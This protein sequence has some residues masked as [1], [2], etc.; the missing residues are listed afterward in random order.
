MARSTQKYR[1][2]LTKISVMKE[3]ILRQDLMLTQLDGFN[4]WE[5]AVELESFTTRFISKDLFNDRLE[6]CGNE[7]LNGMELWRNLYVQYSGEGKLA[8]MTG[9]LQKFLAF[10][11]CENQKTLLAHLSDWK[12]HLDL[13]GTHL[14][15]DAHTLRGLF[16]GLLP[17]DME[18]KLL[19][20][21]G[22]YQTW[23][24]L[25]KYVKD[26]H[27]GAREMEI[28]RAI[29]ARKSPGTGRVFAINEPS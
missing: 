20:K 29:H 22:K 7:E 13:Y 23:Q 5:I 6:L 10:G 17:K 8:V 28:S 19:S 11:R 3:P 27:E 15:H 1:T 21:A 25:H 12:A 2:L 16:I 24:A 9:G 26:K 18:D 14:K 4:A